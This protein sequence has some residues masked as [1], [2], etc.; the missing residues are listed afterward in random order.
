MGRA[1]L[2]FRLN[3]RLGPLSRCRFFNALQIRGQGRALHV[4]F[5]RAFTVDAQRWVRWILNPP[6]RSFKLRV[7]VDRQRPMKN[8]TL[9]R[10]TV[11]QLD[12]NGADSALD[13]AAD[14]N[15]LRN[16]VALDLCAI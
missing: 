14:C 4:L 1:P 15:G 11:L 13:A 16:D 10:T 5:L 9:D 2:I 3:R 8:V 12:A 7:L 6:R